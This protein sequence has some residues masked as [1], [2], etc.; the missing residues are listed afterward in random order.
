MNLNKARFVISANSPADFPN[1]P[2]PEVA[3]AGR[4]N[5]GKSSFLNMVTGQKKLA[6]VSSTPGRT[7]TI[8]FF[9]VEDRAH[10]VDLPGYGYAKVPKTVKE[11]WGRLIEHY[12]QTREQL[13]SV[14]LLVDIRHEP[15]A[16]DV[17][18]ASWL[19]HG[20]AEGRIEP[21]VIA[22][23]CDKVKRSKIRSHLDIVQRTLGLDCPYIAFSAQTGTGR[24][25]AIR[26][27]VEKLSKKRA[28]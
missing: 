23:K 4:S 22:T 18:M 20:Q 26:L 3:F 19:A 5:V 7:Q 15:T 28:G 16:D 11:Q 1:V 8:N 24:E 13:V 17:L 27:I 14:F 2:W 12:L 25:E 6:K 10:L 9:N 21:V